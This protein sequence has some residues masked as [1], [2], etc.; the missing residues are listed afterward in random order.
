[1]S[2]RVTLLPL[3]RVEGAHLAGLVDEFREVIAASAFTDDAAIDRL[4]PEVYPEDAEASAAFAEST[5]AELLDRRA[6]D[7]AIVRANLETFTA[8]LTDGDDPLAP[9]DVVI[10]DAELPA[11]LRTLTA[12]R[13]VIASRLGISDESDDSERRAQDPRF[14]VY[15][16]LGFRLEGLVEAADRLL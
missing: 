4:A 1:M 2:D 15:D 8:A 7:A 13:L 12:L 9:L 6:Q 14:A 10:P 5:R 3:A 11:W 16:W